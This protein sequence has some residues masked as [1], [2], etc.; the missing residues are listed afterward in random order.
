MEALSHLIG[1]IYDAV[2]DPSL[3]TSVLA[4]TCGFTDA[5]RAILIHEDGA[6]P[7]NSLFE[8]SFHDPDWERLYLNSYMMINP[9]R[10][11]MGRWVKPGDVVLTT[12]YM[13]E[14]EYARTRFVR[15]FLSLRQCVDVAT[16]I[17]DVAPTSFTVLGVVRN[18][19][20]GY[21]DAEVGRRLA[22]LAPHFRRAVTLGNLFERRRMMADSL[23]ATVAGL[24]AGVFILA[25]DAGVAYAN[26]RALRMVEDGQVVRID[27]GRL[28]PLDTRAR[29]A[30]A[31]ALGAAS[32][33]DEAL[34]DEDPSIVFRSAGG[35]AWIGT[36]MA[37]DSGRRR[38]TTFHPGAVATLCLREASP[39]TPPV[40]AALTELYGLT[41]REMTVLSTLMEANGVADA[42]DLLGVSEGTLKSHL[43]SIFR[44]TGTR[45]QA[46][47]VKLAAAVASPFG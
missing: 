23:A 42:A 34:G 37:L 7:A 31:A 8:I 14:G 32:H 2:V 24:K 18:Q 22:L 40:P 3:W 6:D 38:V 41:R 46:D 12:D 4:Q 44:K 27:K 29:A 13:T 45:R 11:A 16:A 36:V 5:E 25:E 39:L 9:A 1:Q 15:E 30:L 43:K 19:A 20:Q 28:A 26:D 21:A 47:L 33:G 35:A 17:L 10:L